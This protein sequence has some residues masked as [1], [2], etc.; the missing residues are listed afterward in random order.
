MQ[1]KLGMNDTPDMVFDDW[2]RFEM[3]MSR[4]SDRELVRTYADENVPTYDLLIEN[5]VKFIERPIR[6]PDASTVDRIFVTKEWHI[7]SQVYAQ[8]PAPGKVGP[9][10]AAGRVRARWA[11]RSSSSTR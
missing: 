10:A 1:Q 8:R 4:Y 11:S 3:P 2:V 9:G 7:P 5:G 6:S